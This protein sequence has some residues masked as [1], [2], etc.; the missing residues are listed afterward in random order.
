MSSEPTSPK[1]LVVVKV[2]GSLFEWPEL[3]PRL[4]QFCATLADRSIVLFPGGGKAVDAFREL[5]RVHALGEELS[6]WLALRALTVN[7]HFLAD[8]FGVQL[9]EGLNA[10]RSSLR[11]NP[12]VVL[13][14]FRFARGDEDRPGHLPHNWSATSDSFA[15][16]VARIADAERLVLLKSV[17]I[18]AG[19]SWTEASSK[20]FI[21]PLF[22]PT[23][24]GA[25]FTVEA[26]NLRSPND[27]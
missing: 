10:A 7:G 4:Q 27:K 21:D 13:D 1:P 20:G 15:A 3:K 8:L 25:S 5:D 14:P 16:R 23:I 19:L 6:H 24:A 26:V 17:T 18:P 2:G 12:I 22:A 11:R 9:V